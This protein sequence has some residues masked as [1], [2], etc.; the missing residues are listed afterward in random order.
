[1]TTQEILT[2]HS[3]AEKEGFVGCFLWGGEPL[4]RNDIDKILE[5]DHKLGWWVTLATN[6]TFLENKAESVGK[7]VNELLVSVDIPSEK[8]DIIRGRE[9]TFLACKKGIEAVKKK[10]SKC[11][12]KICCVLSQHNKDHIQDIC[13]FGKQIDC[14]I[15]FQHMDKNLARNPRGQ[16]CDLNQEE[17]AHVGREIISLK[18]KGYPIFNSFTYLKQ[19]LGPHTYTCRS[20]R[21][22]LTVWADGGVRSCT[23][24]KDIGNI[25]ETPLSVLMNSESYLDSLK[26][27]DKCSRCRDSGTWETTHVYQLKGEPLINM[28]HQIMRGI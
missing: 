7:Y 2:L 27:S 21:I 15:V 6:G 10:N 17:R 8:H 14:G 12:I 4:L 13:E 22:Y 28:A 9:G 3:E 26:L 24:G 23:T 19:F 18:K 1:M 5:H 20:Q 11:S 25:L 16:T